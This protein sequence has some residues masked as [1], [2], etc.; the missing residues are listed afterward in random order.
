MKLPNNNKAIIPREKLE[1]YL[2]SPVHPIGR[3]KA[4][5]FHSLGYTQDDW[6]VLADDFRKLLDQEAKESEETEYG[7][8]YEI[9]GTVTGP[10]GHSAVIITV[11]VILYGEE[12]VRFVTA[13][14]ED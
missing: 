2:L 11:W 1:S 9:R 10:N 6:E 8:K 3:Y 4:V 14:P 13:Y 5:F 7:K 12:V